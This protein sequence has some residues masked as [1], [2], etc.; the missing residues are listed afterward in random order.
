MYVDL[1]PVTLRL[2]FLGGLGGKEVDEEARPEIVA[3]LDEQ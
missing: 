2:L 1:V 3:A